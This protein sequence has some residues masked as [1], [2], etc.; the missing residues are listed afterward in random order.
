MCVKF[1][2][3]GVGNLRWP[4]GDRIETIDIRY[5]FYGPID[6]KG[7]DPF[8]ADRAINIAY[9]LYKRYFH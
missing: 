8:T 2:E 1:L 6:L 4:K 3:R 9:K 5:I 7:V